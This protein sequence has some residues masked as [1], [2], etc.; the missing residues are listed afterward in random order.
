[1]IAL[2]AGIGLALV[3]LVVPSLRGLYDY[4][5]F[6]GFGVSAVIYLLLARRR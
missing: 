4:A 6:V 5:W 1:M 2:G 3:G